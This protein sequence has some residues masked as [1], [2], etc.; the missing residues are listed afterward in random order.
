MRQLQGGKGAAIEHGSSYAAGPWKY[1]SCQTP[2]YVSIPRIL[3]SLYQNPV[4]RLVQGR[5]LTHWLPRYS[6][7]KK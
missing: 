1:S 5:V 6:A 2:A 4:I 7:S 3:P